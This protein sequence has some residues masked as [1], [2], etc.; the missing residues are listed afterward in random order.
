MSD[1]TTKDSRWP[2]ADTVE[3]FTTLL[4][5]RGMTIFAVID[6]QAAAR[7]VG[8]DLRDTVLILFGN[9]AGGT[10]IMN[11]EPLSG[12]DLP[13]KLLVWDD[14]GHTKVSYLTPAA[15]GARYGIPDALIAPLA[16]IDALTDAALVVDDSKEA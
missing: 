15:L 7:T 14:G 8:Q 9:P 12:L 2:V 6:Q 5:E 11:A 3:R 16:G 10:P 13:L 4:G 1:H